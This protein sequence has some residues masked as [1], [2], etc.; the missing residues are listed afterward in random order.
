M[1]SEPLSKALIGTWELLIRVDRTAAGERRIEPALG[2]D[3]V[4]AGDDGEPVTRTLVWRRAGTERVEQ[5]RR[6][7]APGTSANGLRRG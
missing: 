6:C 5:M 4:A 1:A 2:E 3:P 7:L